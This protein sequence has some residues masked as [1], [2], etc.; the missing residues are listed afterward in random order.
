MACR[1]N[2][3]PW[4]GYGI[5]ATSRQHSCCIVFPDQ[6][7]CRTVLRVA[8]RRLAE[9]RKAK[10]LT[11]GA[12]ATLLHVDRTTPGRWE[13][14]AS[15]P[16]PW[17]RADLAAA[18]GIDLDDLDDLLR[19]DDELPAQRTP[20][21]VASDWTP[22]TAGH[23]AAAV[24]TDA[25]LTTADATRLV[26]EWLVVEPPQSVELNAGRRIGTDLAQRVEQRVDQLRRLDD[27]IA[28]TDLQQIIDREMRATTDL[29]QDA[30]YTDV[31]GRRLLSALGDLCQLAGWAAADADQNR[32]AVH[33]YT[34]GIAAAH[35]ADD[36]PLAGQLITTLAYH[37]ANTGKARD[38]VLLA[39]TAVAGCR[40]ATTPT[41]MALLLERLA[42]AFALNRDLQ[43]ERTLGRVEDTFTGRNPEDD[44]PWIY[45]L[46][47]EEIDVMAGRCFVELSQPNRA[48]PL[49]ESALVGYGD[50]RPRETG[51]YLS[52]LAEAYYQ[53]GEI[54][55]AAQLG[56]R[57]LDLTGHTASIRPGGRAR[58][59]QRL[60]RPH[61]GLPEVDEFVAR[62]RAQVGLGT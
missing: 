35:A 58:H 48:V 61:R 29:V 34:T 13:R 36:R 8:R 3:T 5:E 12:L 25:P 56:C 44:P 23:L 24:H 17:Q 22:A 41:V 4:S 16:Q 21:V 27:L 33:L 37:L 11:Q 18:L 19:H 47:T 49:L 60:L 30:S 9:A 7:R 51:L 39:Q 32:A 31:I 15:T 38:A 50:D 59:L 28:G 26:H 14:G 54:E 43:T 45:W 1:V 55:R 52:W 42:W 62:Y 10:G 20:A 57:V 40:T 6:R 53:A 46:T 2:D